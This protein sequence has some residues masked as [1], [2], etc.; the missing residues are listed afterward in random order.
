M[1]WRSLLAENLSIVN[2]TFINTIEPW[3]EQCL[4]LPFILNSLSPP[5]IPTLFPPEKPNE[6]NGSEAPSRK[7]KSSRMSIEKVK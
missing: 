7:E 5:N 6:Q 3:L 4:D 2:R 1:H